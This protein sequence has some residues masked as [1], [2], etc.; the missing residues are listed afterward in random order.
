MHQMVPML[1]AAGADLELKSDQLG[2]PIYAAA[3]F[4]YDYTVEALIQAGANPDAIDDMFEETALHVAAQFGYRE[5]ARVLIDGGADLN[6]RDEE[7][8][9]AL[10]WAQE[11]NYRRIVK[12]LKKHG[13]TL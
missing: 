12:L 11:Y 3:Y 13:A 9:T 5:V 7:G 1:T 6:L 2:P 8:Y 4:G 10:F